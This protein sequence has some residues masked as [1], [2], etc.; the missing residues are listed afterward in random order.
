MLKE[1]VRLVSD[2]QIDLSK[3]ITHRYSLDDI[4]K[5]MLATEKY[6]GLR[7]VINRFS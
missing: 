6:Y 3:I 2:K 4:Q 7:A 5:A 1:A